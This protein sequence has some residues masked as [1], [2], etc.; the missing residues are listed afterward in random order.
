MGVVYEPVEDGVREGGVADDA[1]PVLEGK[2]GGDKGGAPLVTLLDDLE[3]VS[4][5]LVRQEG[6]APVV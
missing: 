5:F 6:R 1:V 2:L 4:S 3:E